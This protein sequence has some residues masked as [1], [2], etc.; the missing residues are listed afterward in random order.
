MD[1]NLVFDDLNDWKSVNENFTLFHYLSVKSNYEQIILLARLFF[2]EIITVGGCVF[3]KESRQLFEIENFWKATKNLTQFE[4]AINATVLSFIF[5]TETEKE[6]NMSKE[7][8]E[9]LKKSWKLY[10]YETY[11]ELDLEVEIYNDEYDGWC[12]TV[13]QKDKKNQEK[14]NISTLVKTLKGEESEK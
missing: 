14:P 5:K 13:Y 3:L 11:K 1:V 7:V 2:P 10:F 6:Y 12:I 8:A 9:I 4:K